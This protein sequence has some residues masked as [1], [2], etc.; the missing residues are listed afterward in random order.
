MKLHELT[1]SVAGSHLV[2]VQLMQLLMMI[3]SITQNKQ[4]CAILERR[5][6]TTFVPILLLCHIH[7]AGEIVQGNRTGFKAYEGLLDGQGHE[8]VYT[9][10]NSWIDWLF[11]KWVKLRGPGSTAVTELLNIKGVSANSLWAGLV[12]FIPCYDPGT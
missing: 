11:G 7:R 4:A 6:R 10:F 9:P 2:L 5:Q 3:H 12:L 8:N 1:L